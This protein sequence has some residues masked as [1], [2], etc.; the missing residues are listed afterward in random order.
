MALLIFYFRYK[1]SKLIVV[2]FTHKTII[3]WPLNLH[4]L[5]PVLILGS[6]SFIINLDKP[7]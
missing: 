7:Y 6:Y 1:I 3:I 4:N 2:Y 5:I